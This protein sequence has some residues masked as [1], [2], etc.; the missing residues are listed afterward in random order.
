MRIYIAGKYSSL[1]P[2]EFLNNIHDGISASVSVLKSGNEVFCPFIDFL[3]QFFDKTL[4]LED[5][6]RY[7]M[8]FLE[9]WAEEVWV[10]PDSENS[11]GTQKEIERAYEL[12]M[13][14]RFL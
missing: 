13:P 4:T 2:I 14:V 9:Y 1:K 5:Y 10:L 11:I 6:Y 3:F 12:N 7:S 8:S